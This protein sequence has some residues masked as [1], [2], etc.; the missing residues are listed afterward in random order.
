MKQDEL[1]N[2]ILFIKLTI[3]YLETHIFNSLADVL[4]FTTNG[5]SPLLEARDDVL[6]SH[7]PHIHIVL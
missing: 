4:C 2:I 5:D 1:H 6:F 3:K 7:T